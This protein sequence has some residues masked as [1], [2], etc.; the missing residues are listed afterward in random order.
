MNQPATPRPV[1]ARPRPSTIIRLTRICPAASIPVKP[2]PEMFSPTG[3]PTAISTATGPLSRASATIRPQTQP[4]PATASVFQ[5]SGS[6][7]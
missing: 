5:N 7:R 4:P 2:T 6:R 1:S 3:A